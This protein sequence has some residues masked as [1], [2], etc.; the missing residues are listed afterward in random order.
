MDADLETQTESTNTEVSMEDTLRATLED[1][2]SR[3]DLP[4][5]VTGDTAATDP[6][7]KARDASGKFTK[8]EENTDTSAT[9]ADPAV[10]NEADKPV[11]KAP[12]SW[13]K[14]AQ[15]KYAT[16]DPTLQDEIDKREAD[17]HKGLEPYK[18]KAQTFDAIDQALRPFAENLRR[19]GANAIQA[20]QHFFGLDNTL[21]HGSP[22]QKAAVVKEIMQRAG[23]TPETLQNAP[24]IDPNLTA[25]Q[26]Q[27]RHLQASLQ[28]RDQM[29]QQAEM[30]QLNSEIAKFANGKEHFETVRQDMAALLQAGRAQN[31]DEAYE[32]AVWA[33]PNTRA[34]LIAQQQEAQKAEASKKAQEARK[35]ATVNIPKRG[36]ISATSSKVGS[37]EDTIRE[38][39]KRLGII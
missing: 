20:I 24:Q 9:S 22:A 27:I 25:V 26:Q 6:T 23:L 5:E 33:N 34:A 32:Q 15:E 31:L 21:R 14:E 10:K 4:E 12:S 7:A 35:A 2:Q 3:G 13:R 36:A 16:L 11:R 18:Q 1:I 38:N 30:A 8:T 39:A 37:M 28:Q 17:F 29:Q 19:E